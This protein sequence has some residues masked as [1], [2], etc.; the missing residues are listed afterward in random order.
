MNDT[1]ISWGRG[2][3]DGRESP[4]A[5]SV[6]DRSRARHLAAVSVRALLD[7]GRRKRR[8]S[9]GRA[10]R[11]HGGDA[12]PDDGGEHPERRRWAARARRPEPPPPLPD[13]PA[14]LEQG[15]RSAVNEVLTG[16]DRRLP[17]DR[18]PR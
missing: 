8:G 12:P 9:R 2:D 18:A 11:L 4:P 6:G 5:P 1:W 15:I 7:E 17:A 16:G 3:H 10:Q 13:L 14:A